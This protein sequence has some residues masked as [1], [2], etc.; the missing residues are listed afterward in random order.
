MILHDY[1]QDVE[2]PTGIPRMVPGA[3]EQLGP[4][5]S[6]FS[7]A[8]FAGR[9]RNRMPLAVVAVAGGDSLV[10]IVVAAAGGETAGNNQQVQ[11]TV[12]GQTQSQHTVQLCAVSMELVA[13]ARGNNFERRLE[14]SLHMMA[15]VGAGVVAGAGLHDWCA[16]G[17]AAAGHKKV[18]RAGLRNSLTSS[19]WRRPMAGGVIKLWQSARQRRKNDHNVEDIG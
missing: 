16:T 4:E 5:H 9:L 18:R 13:G 11:Q 17:A 10:G 8:A 12:E 2:Y 14:K 6:H 19:A 15:V 3:L 1:S 7:V